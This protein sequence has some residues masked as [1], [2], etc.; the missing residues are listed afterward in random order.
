L[1]ATDKATSNPLESSRQEIVPMHTLGPSLSAERNT[2]T[3]K[4]IVET[5][6]D[7]KTPHPLEWAKR[8]NTPILEAIESAERNLEEI[9]SAERNLEEIE[10]AERNLEKGEKA[11][12]EENRATLFYTEDESYFIEIQAGVLNK[13]IVEWCQEKEFTGLEFLA[14]IPGS[15][16]G[17]ISMN[18]GCHGAEIFQFVHSVTGISLSTGEYANYHREEI[19]WHYRRSIFAE[20]IIIT[21]AILTLRKG[22][23]LCIRKKTKELLMLRQ[24]TQPI[25]EMSCGSL[26]R[27]PSP[28][29]KAWQLID[30]CGLRGFSINQATLS[31]LHCNFLINEGKASATDLENVGLSVQ[32]TVEQKTNIKLEWE[33]QRIGEPLNQVKN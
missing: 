24:K 33:I 19:Q 12:S 3:L 14:G 28:E 22:S 25:H 20:K 31:E 1:T 2:P 9:E 8:A 7:Q 15:L 23:G 16:G 4:K 13:K 10:S 17:G 11:Y 21:S 27:N 6:P 32:K 18:A 5:P 29:T 26:F 30:Q